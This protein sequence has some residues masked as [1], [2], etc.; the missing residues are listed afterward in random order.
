M[1]IYGASETPRPGINSAR[2]VESLHERTSKASYV[3]DIA[4]LSQWLEQNISSND[5]VLAIGAGDIY[6]TML[7]FIRDGTVQKV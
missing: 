4:K 3:Q 1:D 2:L 5:V 7:G 6:T